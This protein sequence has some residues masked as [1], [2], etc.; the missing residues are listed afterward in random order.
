MLLFGCLV[1]DIRSLK[2]V[3]HGINIHN[4]IGVDAG[5]CHGILLEYCKELISL[6]D[7][8]IEKLE[9]ATSN[10]ETQNA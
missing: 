10:K 2:R 9:S 5:C 3:V 6:K 1:R 7:G 8:C 4:V